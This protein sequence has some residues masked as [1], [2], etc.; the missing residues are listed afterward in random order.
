M[1]APLLFRFF[2]GLTAVTSTAWSQLSINALT[3]FGGGDG[4]LTPAEYPFLSAANSER[5]LAV[6]NGHLY[7]VSRA[8]GLSIRILDLLTG[9]ETT[10]GELNTTAADEFGTPIISG[11][12]FALNMIAVGGDG[13]IYAANLASTA[14]EARPFKV[15]RWVNEGAL[16]AV[17]FSGIPLAGRIGDTLDAIGSGA[18]TRLVAGFGSAPS[19]PGNNGY[20]VIDPN[21]PEMDGF[22]NIGFATGTTAAGDFRLGIT[23]ANPDQV[24]GAPNG[25]AVRYT[26]FAGTQGT[27]D[28]TLTLATAIR[29][30]DFAVIGGM[31]LLA[32]IETGSAATANT[33]HVYD[34]TD[35]ANPREVAVA[36]NTVGTPTANLNGTGQV[37]WGPV[38]GLTATL[39]A[40]NTNNGIQA[41]T[42][43]IPEPSSAALLVISALT[44]ACRRRADRAR[45][46]DD[47]RPSEGAAGRR[48]PSQ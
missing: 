32:T 33:V 45:V 26:S 4:W 28:A 18:G 11:G 23:F 34:L 44:L 13:V 14:T 29:P 3:S 24:I 8:S 47:T 42:L 37:K 27:L 30:M 7:L 43:I 39:Y 12:D 21:D 19:V 40:M 48:L 22:T 5:G 20:T 16:P 35:P 2:V 10:Q 46:L 36:N 15:Y 9:A 17:A 25:A 41:F 6:G 38:N 31:P 1:T